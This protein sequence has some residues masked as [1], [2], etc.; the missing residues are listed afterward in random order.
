MLIIGKDCCNCEKRKVVIIQKES[1]DS[2][3]ELDVLFELVF[4]DESSGEDL[5]S[6]ELELFFDEEDYKSSDDYSKSS[7]SFSLD[8][9]NIDE[10]DEDDFL[11]SL[12]FE[13]VFNELV[14]KIIKDESKSSGSFSME[15]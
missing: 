14:Y 15:S 11:S 7:G 1:S 3:S 4:S 9:K 5:S 13:L 10:K 6:I 2:E 12:Y 8:S